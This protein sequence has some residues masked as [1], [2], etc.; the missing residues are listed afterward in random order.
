MQHVVEAVLAVRRFVRSE[1]FFS[2]QILPQILIGFVS[3]EL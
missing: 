2:F 1:I 3:I